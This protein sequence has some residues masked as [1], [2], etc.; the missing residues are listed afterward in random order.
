MFT[1]FTGIVHMSMRFEILGFGLGFDCMYRCTYA[2]LYRKYC[3]GEVSP[4]Y[5]P[6]TY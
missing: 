3:D 6:R 1:L 2:F 4:A 5:P